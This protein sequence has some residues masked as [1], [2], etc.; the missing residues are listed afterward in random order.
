MTLLSS[1]NGALKNRTDCTSIKENMLPFTVL[2][3]AQIH[4]LLQHRVCRYFIKALLFTSPSF[5]MKIAS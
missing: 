3:Q 1:Y 5:L 2:P 4:I